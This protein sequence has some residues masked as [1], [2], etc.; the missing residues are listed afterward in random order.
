MLY[1]Y[2]LYLESTLKFWLQVP[3]TI[4]EKTSKTIVTKDAQWAKYNKVNA[5]LINSKLNFKMQQN[6]E[7]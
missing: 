6:G 5:L 4:Q 1:K 7:I 2:Q 3:Y